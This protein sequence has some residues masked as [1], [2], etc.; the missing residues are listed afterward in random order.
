VEIFLVAMVKFWEKVRRTPSTRDIKDKEAG[1]EEYRPGGPAVIEVQGFAPESECSSVN[2]STKDSVSLQDS[3]SQ[4]SYSGSQVSQETLSTLKGSLKDNDSLLLESLHEDSSLT[5]S[6]SSKGKMKDKKKMT[7]KEMKKKG[8][9]DKDLDVGGVGLIPYPDMKE[10]RDSRESMKGKKGK[11]VPEK[12]KWVIHIDADKDK[13]ALKSIQKDGKKR[14]T[15]ERGSGLERSGSE[16]SA[17]GKRSTI[18]RGSGLAEAKGSMRES[19][20]SLRESKS[21]LKKEKKK[22]DVKIKEDSRTKDAKK[23]ASKEEIKWREKEEKEMK[24]REKEDRERREKEA[25]RQ[26]KAEEEHRKRLKEQKEREEKEEKK[27]EKERLEREEKEAKKREKE[28]KKKRD[29]E[30]RSSLV[31]M[32]DSGEKHEPLPTQPEENRWSLSEREKRA[33]TLQAGVQPDVVFRKEKDKHRK[34]DKKRHSTSDF[35]KRR[36]RE[37]DRH[38]MPPPGFE[39]FEDDKFRQRSSSLNQ[40][41]TRYLVHARPVTTQ[42]Q[43]TVVKKPALPAD[44]QKPQIQP[45]VSARELHDPTDIAMGFLHK[46]YLSP[47]K[48]VCLSPRPAPI[49]PHASEESLNSSFSQKK[50]KPVHGHLRNDS[51]STITSSSSRSSGHSAMKRVPEKPEIIRKK[52]YFHWSPESR[53]VDPIPCP[54]IQHS[55]PITTPKI[56]MSFPDM[57]YSPDMP[58]TN[59][60][61][62]DGQMSSPKKKSGRILIETQTPSPMVKSSI[63]MKSGQSSSPKSQKS[64]SSKASTPESKIE[65][66]IDVATL[67]AEVKV[68]PPKESRI[69]KPHTKSPEQM[70]EDTKC[71]AEPMIPEPQGQEVVFKSPPQTVDLDLPKAP[72]V[73]VEMTKV[74]IPASSNKPTEL[75]YVYNIPEVQDVNLNQMTP[76]SK[77]QY[78]REKVTSTLTRTTKSVQTELSSD[79]NGN[80]FLDSSVESVSSADSGAQGTPIT[81]MTNTTVFIKTPAMPVPSEGKEKNTLHS[82]IPL[83]AKDGADGKKKTRETISVACDTNGAIETTFGADIEFIDADSSIEEQDHSKSKVDEQIRSAPVEEEGLPISL[84]DRLPKFIQLEAPVQKESAEFEEQVPKDCVRLETG[85]FTFATYP[86]P[87]REVI[88]PEEEIPVRETTIVLPKDEQQYDLG[89]ML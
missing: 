49:A 14:I 78:N 47:S 13:S 62:M 15:L 35:S 6:K 60:R 59:I 21:S 89:E 53:V 54:K 1:L 19:K 86:E 52:A 67:Q 69:P 3:H 80:D 11:D 30:K 77:I 12:D 8:D 41:P 4:V 36:S 22:A 66:K 85:G 43:P 34:D 44:N 72:K 79:G 71:I 31:R 84:E 45:A 39:K 17:V 7:E 88:A 37:F 55:I 23:K 2:V 18:E 16:P 38:G 46:N 42:A 70:S 24:K 33:A 28:E 74:P 26:E 83:F 87:T 10:M 48:P 56:Q 29:K 27:R 50:G 73:E 61:Q 68:T 5:G 76:D 82:H 57:N 9:V 75:E 25:K 40:G 65:P 58:E 51:G 64:V 32:F 20:G 81:T 63:S